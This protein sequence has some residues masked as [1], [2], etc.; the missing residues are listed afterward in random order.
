MLLQ[1]FYFYFLLDKIN[2]EFS[3]DLIFILKLYLLR[4]CFE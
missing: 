2:S 4:G 1:V 3:V